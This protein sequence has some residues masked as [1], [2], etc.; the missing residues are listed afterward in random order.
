MVSAVGGDDQLMMFADLVPA[1]PTRAATVVVTDPT[2]VPDS[3]AERY[4]RRHVIVTPGCWWWVGAVSS[5]DGYGRI[6]MRRNNRQRCIGAHRFAALLEYPDLDD[7]AVCE[8]TCNE[9][10]C[11]RIDPA[12]VQ[13]GTQVAN[14]AFA[15]RLGRARGP[16]PTTIWHRVDRSTAIRRHLLAGGDPAR[17]GELFGGAVSD[18]CDRLF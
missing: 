2:L 5:P 14:L 10:L 3:D 12:H 7:D 13:I 15:V 8:H 11:V 1:V 16:H 6:T 9:P 18:S 4:F 17:I